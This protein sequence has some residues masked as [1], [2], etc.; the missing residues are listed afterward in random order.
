MAENLQFVST[1]LTTGVTNAYFKLDSNGNDSGPNNYV[2]SATNGGVSWE[3]GLFGNCMFSTG[4]TSSLISYSPN[5]MVIPAGAKT[6]SFWFKQPNDQNDFYAIISN[7]YPYDGGIA[8]GTTVMAMS[9]GKMYLMI[10]GGSSRQISIQNDVGYLDNT[11]HYYCFTWDGTTNTNGV[12]SYIDGIFHKAATSTWSSE[13]NNSTYV[14][15]FGP[16]SGGLRPAR[17]WYDEFIIENRTWTEAEV[18]LYYQN[19]TYDKSYILGDDT[20][21]IKLL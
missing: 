12:K 5:K 7:T 9:T 21:K 15:G 1:L 8:S 19:R 20:F 6:I 18:G 11:W 17:G 3:A 4:M 14:F 13:P 10:N 2:V 16:Q